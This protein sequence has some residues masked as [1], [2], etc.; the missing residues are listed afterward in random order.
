M[1]WR[2]VSLGVFLF[3]LVMTGLVI[4]DAYFP[5]ESRFAAVPPEWVLEKFL[6]A[7]AISGG[8]LHI[9]R[10]DE[11]LGH[12]SFTARRQESEGQPPSFLVVVNGV[13]KVPVG[14][15]VLEAGFRL[16]ADL[17]KAEQW[18]SLQARIHLPEAETEAKIN[19]QGS[20]KLPEVEV[21]KGNQVVMDSAGLAALLPVA[22]GLAAMPMPAPGVRPLITAREGTLMLAGR[23]RQSY[24][25]TARAMA[26]WEANLYFTELGELARVDLP[27][28]WQLIEPMMHALEK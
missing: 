27:G 20:M 15:Q 25:V 18:K 2:V 13:V 14:P 8:T 21:K 7:P 9:L 1:F 16:T 17:E 24:V 22:G 5:A 3:W 6:T 28:G 23:A 11:K 19:W 12:A 10:S 26:G 4:R